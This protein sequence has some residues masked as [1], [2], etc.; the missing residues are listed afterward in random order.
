[1]NLGY[2]ILKMSST[3]SGKCIRNFRGNQVHVLQIGLGTFG[4]FLHVD[5][6]WMRVI[7]EASTC[8]PECPL[9][10]IGVDP[11]EESVGLHEL[12]DESR[13]H[14]SI[15]LGAVGDRHSTVDLFCLPRDARIS[16][17]K[18]LRHHTL[19]VRELCDREM[20][21]LEN[22]SHIGFSN[23]QFDS[24]IEYIRSLSNT[25]MSLKERRK[26]QLYTFD[27]VLNQSNASGCE[28]LVIDAEGGDC[29]ILRSMLA[30]CQSHCFAWPRVIR[31]ETR[32][33]GDVKETDGVEAAMVKTL[34]EIG[35]V[36]LQGAT[37][38]WPTALPFKVILPSA[39]GPIRISV[40]GAT[41][42]KR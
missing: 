11:V 13:V 22:M 29:A 27:D 35:Y 31:F 9:L 6:L 20:A 16:L 10:G 24:S 33:H 34:Q 38:R 28:I 1:M 41:I 8:E 26:V 17:R 12:H 19:E 5:A 21:Y 25:K 18:E 32:G 40:C 37:P 2:L 4:T 36:L 39:N 7:L 42:A 15:I 30:A 3:Y 23:E 14:A